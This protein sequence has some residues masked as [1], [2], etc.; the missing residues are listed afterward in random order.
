MPTRN[1]LLDRAAGLIPQT[2]SKHFN[3]FL[4]EYTE[5]ELGLI[6]EDPE[7]SFYPIYYLHKSR[8]YLSDYI[9]NDESRVND[10]LEI[11]DWANEANRLFAARIYRILE[12]F[13]NKTLLAVANRTVD[14]H[15]IVKS[16][17]E[18]LLDA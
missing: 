3:E 4:A 16:I 10:I 1:E 7:E 5:S 2:S 15:T 12:I 17:Q 6:C 9:A 14:I 18:D 11:S 8:R 13:D